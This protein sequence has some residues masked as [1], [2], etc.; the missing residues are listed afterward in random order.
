MKLALTVYSKVAVAMFISW[1]A[2]EQIRPAC[3]RA[4]DHPNT[5]KTKPARVGDPDLRA[6]ANS[7]AVRDDSFE[8]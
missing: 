5:R 1:K 8:A 7:T 2:A 4:D 6:R 3:S